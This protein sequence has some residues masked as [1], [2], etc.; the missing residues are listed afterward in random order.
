MVE[1][2]NLSVLMF[3]TGM[4][5]ELNLRLS[6]KKMVHYGALSVMLELPQMILFQV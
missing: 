4:S 5:A 3:P 2:L 1:K 6:Q